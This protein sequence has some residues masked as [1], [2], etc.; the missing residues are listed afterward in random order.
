MDIGVK[1]EGD[2]HFLAYLPPFLYEV[3]ALIES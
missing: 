1:R 2:M 3:D